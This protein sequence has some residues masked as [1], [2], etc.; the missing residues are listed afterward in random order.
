L[1][2]IEVEF[3]KNIRQDRNNAISAGRS[4][5]VQRHTH[6]GPGFSGDAFLG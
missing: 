5:V 3:R 6:A 1:S 4:G 2:A